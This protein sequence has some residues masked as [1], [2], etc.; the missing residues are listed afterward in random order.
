MENVCLKF[1]VDSEDYGGRGDCFLV[2]FIEDVLGV[3]GFL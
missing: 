1:C 3:L 2:L